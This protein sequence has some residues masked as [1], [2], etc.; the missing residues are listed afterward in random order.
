[1]YKVLEKRV[2][3]QRWSLKVCDGRR[4]KKR[5]EKMERGN[6]KEGKVQSVKRDAKG[7]K[8]LFC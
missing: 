4:A 7:G 1:M 8:A 2:K 6:G 5:K 3:E